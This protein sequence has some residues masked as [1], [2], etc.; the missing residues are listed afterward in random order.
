MFLRKY[1]SLKPALL[2]APSYRHY[3]RAENEKETNP[4]GIIVK[5]ETV[6]LAWQ[7]R[8]VVMD[9]RKTLF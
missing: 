8:Q 9:A 3:S 6:R 2:T 4:A 7:E 5:G 1:Y